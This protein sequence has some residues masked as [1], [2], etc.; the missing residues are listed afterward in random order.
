MKRESIYPSATLVKKK[1]K[2]E[3]GGFASA[4]ATKSVPVHKSVAKHDDLGRGHLDDLTG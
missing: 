4:T 2:N 3:K 1:I